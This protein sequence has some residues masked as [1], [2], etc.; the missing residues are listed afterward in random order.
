M[1]ML[2]CTNQDFQHHCSSAW[3]RR[4]LNTWWQKY[5]KA[6]AATTLEARVYQRKSWEQDIIGQHW[7]QTPLH[8]QRSA[9]NV[10]ATVI[11]IKPPRGTYHHHHPMAFPPMGDWYSQS[12]SFGSWEN[13]IL[14]HRHRLFHQMDWDGATSHHHICQGSEVF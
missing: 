9:T 5:M 4:K 7:K 6:S 11:F 13:Q 14:D 8:T 2:G 1:L 3:P 12:I 10:S